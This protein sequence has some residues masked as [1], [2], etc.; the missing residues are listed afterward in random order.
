MTIPNSI[1]FLRILS[2]PLL[3]YLIQEHHPVAAFYLLVGIWITDFLD[4]FV[5]RTFDQRSK[6][7]SYLDPIADKLLTASLF[8]FLTLLGRLPVWLTVMV[9]VRD[10]FIFAGLMI[11]LLPQ[12]FPVAS[13]SYLGKFTTFFQAVMLLVVMSEGVPVFDVVLAPLSET[14]LMITAGL[15]LLSFVQYL[16]RGTMMLKEGHEQH[17]K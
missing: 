11:I 3:F 5:A 17:G 14:V 12:K 1:T 10:I 2:L 4:G 7:G 15:T 6:L 8:I 16:I 13:P 9:V